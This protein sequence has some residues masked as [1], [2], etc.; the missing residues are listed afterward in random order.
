MPDLPP[1]YRR[2]GPADAAKMAALVNI[3]GDGL[4]LHIWATFAQP[5]QTALDVGRDRA[6][7]GLGGFAFENTVVHEVDGRVVAGLIGYPNT[8]SPTPP[9]DLPPPLAPLLELGALAGD[10][11]YLN[12]LATF[13]EYRGLGIASRLLAIAADQARAA[14]LDRIC[15]IV[16][17]ANTNAKRLYDNAGFNQIA[18]RPIVKAGWNHAG[19][20]WELL[21][22]HL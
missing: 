4:P 21:E 19:T 11:W 7:R 9:D 8:A 15:L 20:H 6:A 18:T 14:G 3:A 13:P 12:V 5:G 17:D 22:Q 2:A 10:C 1:S 16:S